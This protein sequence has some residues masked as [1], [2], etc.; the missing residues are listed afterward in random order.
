MGNRLM[1][2]NYLEGYDLIDKNGNP[3]KL[4]Y[5][6]RLQSDAIG[7][8][9]LDNSTVNA[10]Y[11]IN[12]S[13]TV[14]NGLLEV[15]LTGINL[16]EGSS[17]TIDFS[18]SH[19]S[20]S[21][22]T[23]APTQTNASVEVSF[24][25]YLPNNFATVFDMVSDTSFQDAIGTLANIQTMP[26][27]CLG[28]TL[29]DVFNC[30]MS[31]NLDTYIKYTS[32]INSA[33][34]LVSATN[35]F[36]SDIISFQFPAVA[37]VNNLVSPTYRMDS[38]WTIKT[39]KG[40]SVMVLNPLHRENSVF[41]IFEGIVDTDNHPSPLNF[42]FTLLEPNFEGLIPA[43]TPFAQIIPFKRDSWKMK[44]EELGIPLQKHFVKE[45]YKLQS[46]FWN[47][48]KNKI[49]ARKSFE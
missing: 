37:Y 14:S 29:S 9:L 20:F 45:N 21:G 11:T 30:A 1:Y 35:T 38:P 24:T 28:V 34:L 10:N 8:N 42:P 27:A 40:Y 17:I 43:G 31:Q 6:T 3:V 2:G 32:G 19:F 13:V 41:R 39:P 26:N 15:D 46:S 49:W 4:E 36:G 5:T 47:F 18:L 12:G 25:Y 22:S 7:L 33:N 44:I 48:Y 23:P 16:S